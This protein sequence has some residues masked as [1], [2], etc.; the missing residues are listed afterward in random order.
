M[1]GVRGPVWYC[2]L[3]L[4]FDTVYAQL[5]RKY[6]SKFSSSRMLLEQMTFGK[7]KALN[8]ST[9]FLIRLIYP[10]GRNFT[11]LNLQPAYLPQYIYYY[12]FGIYFVGRSEPSKPTAI[13]TLTPPTYSMFIISSFLSTTSL[14]T[15]FTIYASKCPL[16]PSVAGSILQLSHT[17]YGMRRRGISSVPPSCISLHAIPSLLHLPRLSFTVNGKSEI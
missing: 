7:A 15:L 10:V 3:L 13:S 6:P 5:S 2:T 4:I 14:I 8:I 11:P 12:T 1:K 9:S 17:R 16:Y